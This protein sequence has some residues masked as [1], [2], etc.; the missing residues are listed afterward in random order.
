LKAKSKMLNLSSGGGNGNYIRFSPQ[1]NAWTNNLGEEIQLGKVVFDIDGVQTGWLELGVGV[2]DWQAD[3]ELGRKGPQPT[4]NHKRG[5][6]I[7]LYNKTIG[8]CEWSSSGVGPNMGLEKLYTDC[9]AQRA[10]NAGKLPVLEY[11]G[12]KLEKIGKGTTRIPNFNIVSW[13]ERPAG[14][15]QSDAEYIAQAVAAPPAPVAKPT[16]AAKPTP[17]AAAM[18]AAVEDD[19]MF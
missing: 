15:D 8:S 6:I 19:E 5:F 12:S 11:T 13:I 2:R 9:A 14:M 7:T 4:P 17:A 16:N 3:S 18:A 10:A 1:A